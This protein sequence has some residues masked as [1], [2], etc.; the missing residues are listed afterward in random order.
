VPDHASANN[1]DQALSD[2]RELSWRRK[3][4]GDLARPMLRGVKR[5]GFKF[6]VTKGQRHFD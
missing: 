3:T 1:R 5:L 6:T 2:R 4:I